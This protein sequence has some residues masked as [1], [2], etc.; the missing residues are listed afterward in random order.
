[1]THDEENRVIETP[2]IETESPQEAQT[3]IEVPREDETSIDAPRT[4]RLSLFGFIMLLVVI[5]ALGWAL[6]VAWSGTP[7]FRDM[8]KQ[9]LETQSGAEVSLGRVGVGLDGRARIDKL[10][11]VREKPEKSRFTLRAA[12][13][14]IPRA[15]LMLL[16]KGEGAA[17]IKLREVSI[18]YLK[19]S[20][21]G[22]KTASKT[23]YGK[24]PLAEGLM[25]ID[26]K[27]TVEGELSGTWD[28]DP[29][30]VK[31]ELDLKANGIDIELTSPHVSD[32][33]L[34]KLF[35][36]PLKK[37]PSLPDAVFSADGTMTGELDKPL[38]AGSLNLVELEG[39]TQDQLSLTADFN[40]RDGRTQFSDI[41]LKSPAGS[42][43]GGFTADSKREEDLIADLEIA[44]FNPYLMPT[45][46]GF[47][48][49]VV[50]DL[51]LVVGGAL[52]GGGSRK[53]GPVVFETELK[54]HA[55]SLPGSL[56]PQRIAAEAR[57][58]Y[59]GDSLKLNGCNLSLDDG[60]KC[61]LSGRL[62][63]SAGKP[64]IRLS[65]EFSA[66]EVAHLFRAGMGSWASGAANGSFN[67]VWQKN[68]SP[69]GEFDF[70]MS[71]GEFQDLY[72][73]GYSFDLPYES[74][75]VRGLISPGGLELSR[76][77]LESD[78]LSSSGGGN[79]GWSG[80]LAYAGE[81]K[82]SRQGT[83]L[84]S[85]MMG[86]N[87][88]VGALRG[89]AGRPLDFTLEGPIAQPRLSVSLP[90]EFWGF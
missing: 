22:D 9:T 23:Y 52:R 79:A 75:N 55:V 66:S 37:K 21:K 35:W 14:E 11:V 20:K 56:A 71:E 89:L 70:G 59:D 6:L 36:N 83:D 41:D 76:V 54:A 7:H 82:F 8:L 67:L 60:A 53:A 62:D 39:L 44:D 12:S 85:R 48:L 33:T 88:P 5:P 50:E 3:S 72:L 42:I 58:I 49:P 90:G 29:V 13:L 25:L 2:E 18:D 63:W 43:R 51:E 28:G 24:I 26:G 27:L 73:R 4:R 61:S 81:V 1:V 84:L 68:L 15:P 74:L 69:T 87:E 64:D 40:T 16:S 46:S 78:L 45:I 80:R 57:V 38:T 77:R 34:E 32:E 30:T 31:G 47:E 86:L 10:T 65:G 19:H 17:D